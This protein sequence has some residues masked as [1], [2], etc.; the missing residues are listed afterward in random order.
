MGFADAV[1]I[2][3]NGNATV[4]SYV[5]GVGTNGG[6]GRI[7]TGQAFWVQSVAINPI[8]SISETSKSAQESKT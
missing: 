3:D 4:A 1:Y 2:R 5:S 7:A 8:L 6:T